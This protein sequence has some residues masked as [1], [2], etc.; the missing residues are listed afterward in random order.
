M[1]LNE[2][3]NLSA[4]FDEVLA[5]LLK[6]HSL[7]VE[8]LTEKQMATALRQ[9]IDCGDFTRQVR[10][11]DNAQT[12]TYIPFSRE[13]ELKSHIKELESVIKV[14]APRCQTCGKHGS[15]TRTRHFENSDACVW[16]CCN[17]D[18]SNYRLYFYTD[19]LDRK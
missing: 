16:E 5:V 12:V 18:C 19:N 4:K 11:T 1:N 6:K 17:K 14:L 3:S 2:F 8:Q 7:A 10:V 13:K 9:A 15:Y